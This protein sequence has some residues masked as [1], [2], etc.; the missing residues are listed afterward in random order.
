[1]LYESVTASYRTCVELCSGAGGQALG[2]EQAG[3]AH[4]ALV[5]LDHDSCLTL[6]QNRPDWNVVQADIR[7]VECWRIATSARPC[8]LA[9]GVPCPPFSIAGR[10]LGQR[11]ERDLIPAVLALIPSVQPRAILLENVR[12]LLQEKFSAYRANIIRAL[13][14]LGYTAEWRLLYAR[15]FGVPQ[16]RP[17]A[18]LVGLERQAF[19]NF[20][21]PT[22]LTLVTETVHVGDV[23]RESMASRGWKLADVWASQAQ[24]IAPTLCGGSRKHGGPD[25]GPSRAREAWAEIGVNGSSVADEPP[26]PH[27][28]LPVR[29][30]APQLALLQGFP[31]DWAF[32]GGKT[33]VCRQVGNAFPPPVARAVGRAIAEALDEAD[34]SLRDIDTPHSGKRGDT[35]SG[36]IHL[37]PPVTRPGT[38]ACPGTE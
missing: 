30:T 26:A 10:Q 19:T 24:R 8:L 6:R 33:S 22:G 4:Q 29:L 3:F 16:L 18:V 2:L 21:W 25:L 15:D 13:S 7:S 11:D 23:L 17:R 20:H 35:D 9:A 28:Q 37:P 36:M 31:P 1:M 5:D 34:T 12:G 32:T 27:D 14:N 38:S